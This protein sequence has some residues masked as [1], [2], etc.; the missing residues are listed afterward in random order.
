MSPNDD[1]HGMY[2]E[3]MAGR[4]GAGAIMLVGH[5]PHLARLAGLLLAEDADKAPIR[6]VN[7]GVLK[8]CPVQTGWAVQ[9]YLTP[10]CVR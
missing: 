9:W 1:P 7:S 6:F 2:D 4:D 3:L 10:D 5:L 8:I